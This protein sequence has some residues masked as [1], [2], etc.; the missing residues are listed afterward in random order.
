MSEQ[1]QFSYDQDADVLTIEGI[2]YAGG[3]FRM[4]AAQDSIG[5]C[6]RILSNADGLVV[7]RS[8]DVVGLLEYWSS[9]GRLQTFGDR[10]RFRAAVRATLGHGV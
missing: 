6:F 8:M 9:E 4:M 10:E 1:L 5:G 7:M 3:L 2:R